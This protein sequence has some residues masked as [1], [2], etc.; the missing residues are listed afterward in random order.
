MPLLLRPIGPDDTDFLFRLYAGTRDAE[1]G[2]VPWNAEQKEAFLRQQFG[3]Q[4]HHYLHNY[5]GASLDLVLLEGEPVGRLYVARWESEIRIMDITL[6]P[7]HC[8]QGHGGALLGAL[9]AEADQA[10][11]KVSIHVESFNPARRLYQ[12]LGFVPAGEHGVYLLME[13]SPPVLAG[14][15]PR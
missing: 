10:G 14:L 15:P 8:G 3:A 11:K 4:S 5:P 13:R 9:L 2:A 1:L 7:A 12:R 6:L